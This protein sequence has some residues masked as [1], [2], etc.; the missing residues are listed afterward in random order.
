MKFLSVNNFVNTTMKIADKT[1]TI[2]VVFSVINSKEDK[3][4][5]IS[6][7]PLLIVLTDY[8]GE[9]EVWDYNKILEKYGEEL[10]LSLPKTDKTKNGMANLEINTASQYS[11]KFQAYFYNRQYGKLSDKVV[12]KA[13]ESQEQKKRHEVVK[14]LDI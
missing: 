2:N 5:K 10:R 3:Y 7:T 8:E 11:E 1:S 9:K 4:G 12:T 6:A 14:E 13:I